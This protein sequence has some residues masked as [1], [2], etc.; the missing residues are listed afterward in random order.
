MPEEGRAST[1]ARFVS[2]GLE[3][4]GLDAGE[5][6]LAVIEVVDALYGPPLRALVGAELDGVEPEAGIDPSHAPRGLESR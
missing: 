1:T 5:A 3:M 4:L 2:D 6:E